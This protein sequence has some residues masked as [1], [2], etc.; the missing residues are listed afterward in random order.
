MNRRRL[1]LAALSFFTIS[2]CL[3]GEPATSVRVWSTIWLPWYEAYPSWDWQHLR[4]PV[5]I[6][7]PD[8]EAPFPDSIKKWTLD[9]C[10]ITDLS[11][12]ACASLPP[13]ATGS[14][15]SNNW[16]PGDFPVTPLEALGEGTFLCAVVGDGHRYS[17]VSRVNIDHSA[18][19]VLRPQMRLFGISSPQGDICEIGL[20]V[21]PA[22]V[23]VPQII[24][25]TDVTFPNLSVDGTW[26][27]TNGIIWDG[28][29]P[30]LR[31]GQGW[32]AILPLDDYIPT[33]KPFKT[34]SVQVRIV[35]AQDDR[36]DQL[37]RQQ[38]I[39]PPASTRPEYLSPSVVI[40]I[41]PEDERK[42]D[43]A[44]DVRTP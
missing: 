15:Y 26:S 22:Q 17:N 43:R 31:L 39:T 30:V 23:P 34:A 1:F 35:D 19:I 27:Q 25:L 11:H 13:R 20:F 18:S 10:S 3:M 12:Q 36:L 8:S 33:I 37:K 21:V 5:A 2:G 41:N 24:H 6:Q 44:F 40:S 4:C 16:T 9:V 7:Q 42:F 38:G 14:A 29:N 32:G 28:P